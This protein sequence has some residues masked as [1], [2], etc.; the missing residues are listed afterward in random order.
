MCEKM[1]KKFA[2]SSPQEDRLWKEGASWEEKRKP[3]A[4]QKEQDKANVPAPEEEMV[5]CGWSLAAEPKARV[6]FPYLPTGT[7][8]LDELQLRYSNKVLP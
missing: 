2:D 1:G 8:V 5:T 7:F 4:R 3:Q 6:P